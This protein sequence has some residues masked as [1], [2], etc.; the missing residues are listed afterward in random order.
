[1]GA[2]IAWNP[3]DG[4]GVATRQGPL[5]LAVLAGFAGVLLMLRPTIEQH[6]V[7]A[8]LV[9]LLSGMLSA[10]AYLQVMALGRIGEPEVRTVFYFAAGSAVAGAVGMLVTGVAAWDWTHAAWL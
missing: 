4:S 7:F 6:Q 10:F 9:G 8:G 2:L 5:A 3:R 1:G